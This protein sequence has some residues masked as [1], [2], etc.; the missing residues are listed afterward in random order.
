VAVD[1]EQ[2]VV[3]LQE[4]AFSDSASPSFVSSALFT[5][6]LSI[7]QTAEQRGVDRSEL[8]T[9]VRRALDAHLIQRPRRE[10]LV[11]ICHADT[12]SSFASAIG[13]VLTDNDVSICDVPNDPAGADFIRVLTDGFESAD[14]V[15]VLISAHLMRDAWSRREVD[16]IVARRLS[17]SRKRYPAIVPVRVDDVS[18]PSVLRDIKAIDVRGDTHDV[19]ASKVHKAVAASLADRSNL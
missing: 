17:K 6:W 12:E 4:A 7:V 10:R 13:R 14:V 15:V 3:A 11:Y 8:L 18:P 5:D 9:V 2:T 19:A 16:L 1:L